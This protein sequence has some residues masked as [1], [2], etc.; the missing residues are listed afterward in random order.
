[1][2]GGPHIQHLD[3]VPE[4]EMLRFEYADGRTASVW[5]RWIEMSP[6]YF[7]FWNRWEPGAL[8]PLHGHTGDHIVLILKGEIRCGDIVCKAGTHIMLEW[9][10]LF[11]PWEAGPEGCELYGFIAGE[12]APFSGPP[13]VFQNFM[14]EK[15]CRMV[16][17][18]MPKRL[19][20]WAAVHYAKGGGTGV[21]D[22]T[23]DEK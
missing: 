9:G 4:E 8:S 19:P 18:P 23:A 12:G 22:W 16:P 10:D 14:A 15:G 2:R 17:L 5:E 13:E 6:R 11:G 20:P 3:E 21:T 1:M 7:A